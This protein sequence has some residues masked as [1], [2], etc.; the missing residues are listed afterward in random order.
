MD[1]E[2]VST[3]SAIKGL[4]RDVVESMAI[5]GPK[6]G[7]RGGRLESISVSTGIILKIDGKIEEEVVVKGRETSMGQGRMGH[8]RVEAWPTKEGMETPEYKA[9]VRKVRCEVMRDITDT[10]RG[11]MDTPDEVSLVDDIIWV[12]KQGGMTAARLKEE[13]EKFVDEFHNKNR[14]RT[15]SLNPN[16]KGGSEMA[17]KKEETKK[18]AGTVSMKPVK[19]TETKTDKAKTA[20]PGANDT[21]TTLHALNKQLGAVG[22]SKEPN[23]RKAANKLRAE[24]RSI[25]ASSNGTFSVDE[26]G[27]AV[28]VKKTVDRPTKVPTK[29]DKVM[30]KCPCCGEETKSYFAM[31]HDG[32]VKGMFKR[33]LD[34]KAKAEELSN[35]TLK[36]MF[37]V[38]KKDPSQRIVDVA[39]KVMG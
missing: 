11:R 32:R 29:K 30:R 7:Y 20:A 13:I 9:L 4:D 8:I 37:K 18:A 17:T 22:A 21:K 33:I 6:E 2:A 15:M 12:M 26:F 35:D 28:Q 14:G 1:A 10:W 16:Q 5:A 31:G 3:G 19:T 39:K 27:Y 25:V 34:G 36:E 24:I 23:D 38:Y